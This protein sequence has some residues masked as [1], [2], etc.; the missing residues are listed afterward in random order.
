MLYISQANVTGHVGPCY[1]FF[2]YMQSFI[3]VV[4]LD[5]FSIKKFQLAN[6]FF[7]HNNSLS[8]I[9]GRNYRQQYCNK[10]RC[11]YIST[12]IHERPLLANY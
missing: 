10:T 6:S 9:M 1:D 3:H 11:L 12:S 2:S 7:I 4:P 8:K 5:Q